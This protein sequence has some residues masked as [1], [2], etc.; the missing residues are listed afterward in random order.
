MKYLKEIPQGQLQSNNQIKFGQFGMRHNSFILISHYNHISKTNISVTKQYIFYF[1]CH[2]V[3]CHDPSSLFPF[4]WIGMRDCSRQG[5]HGSTLSHSPPP[6]QLLPTPAPLTFFLREIF[7]LQVTQNL[8]G[9]LLIIDI[10]YGG[11]VKT[12]LVSLFN[13]MVVNPLERSRNSSEWY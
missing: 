5:R 9:I 4:P 11:F 10:R 7:C 8:R 6:P 13:K 3:F 12:S 1:V 2:L